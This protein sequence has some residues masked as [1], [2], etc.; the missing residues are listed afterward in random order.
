MKID[1]R[2]KTAYGRLSRS[3]KIAFLSI[4]IGGLLAHLF[5]FTNVIPNFD[6]ISRV[7][8]EQ[9]MTIAGRW[10]LHYATALNWFT[11]MPM[12]IGVLSNFFLA[13]SGMLIVRLF[14]I[15]NGL[16]AGLWGLVYAVFPAMADT[17]AYTF[18]ASAYA[19]A[20]FLAV[21][22]VAF[23]KKGK[24]GILAGA[25]FLALAMGVY[26]AYAAVAIV[27]SVL[28]VIREVTDPDSKTV[29]VLKKSVGYI[30]FL[31]GGAVLYYLILQVFLRVKDL[32]MW[33]YLGM[34]NVTKGYPFEKL[35]EAFVQSYVQ[36]GKFFFGGANG[37]NNPLFLGINALL[38]VIS[39]ALAIW[40]IKAN[41]LYKTP[42]KL[43]GF[44][45]LLLL[46]PLAANFVQ[47]I[48]PLSTPRLLMKFAFVY[49]YLL[50]AVLFT[51]V[52]T[53]GGCEKGKGGAKLVIAAS[54]LAVS[55]YF[56][57]YDNLLYTML[58]HAHR[59][60]LSYTTRMV[61]RIESCEDYRYGMQIVVIGGFPAEK[62]DTDLETFAVVRSESAF[63]SSVIPLNKHIYYY[64]N[65]WLNVRAE[66]PADELCL[67]ITQTD[68]FRQMPLYPDAGSVQVIDDCVVVKVSDEYYPKSEFEK[69]YDNRR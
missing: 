23:A 65:D 64:M 15:N 22:G 68:T 3:E 1:E 40:V 36:V 62:Y 56:W 31:S 42:V 45:V 7:Y 51:R 25:L 34:D 11:Q 46:L 67:A 20:I 49:L 55:V 2:I 8:E 13:L 44:V 38:V 29:A 59:A 52:E 30:V 5:I 69:Q 9:Q 47:I 43:A 54:L 6:G 58:D 57:Q 53:A 63:S 41:R 18:T 27:L 61:S 50:P 28:L 24:W 17:Y 12:V 4:F 33:S 66:E 39:L 16:I 19:V 10:F 48:S 26:Q 37:L 35:P 60:T 14:R 32:Q 21:T